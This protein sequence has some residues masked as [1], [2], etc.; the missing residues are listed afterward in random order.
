MTQSE[1]P[2]VGMVI[3]CGVDGSIYLVT[4]VNQHNGTVSLEPIGHCNWNW[5]SVKGPG[6]HWKTMLTSWKL[7]I[8][9]KAPL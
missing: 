6:W 9:T 7:K 3:E 5:V 8:I 4:A 1:E 2:E